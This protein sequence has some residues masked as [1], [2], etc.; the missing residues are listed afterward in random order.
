MSA[1]VPRSGLRHRISDSPGGGWFSSIR[2][3]TAGNPC[4]GSSSCSTALFD[5]GSSLCTST[6]SSP[7]AAWTGCVHTAP[8]R[9]AVSLP[10]FPSPISPETLTR[11]SMTA[12]TA[13]RAVAPARV[14]ASM[15]RAARTPPRGVRTRLRTMRA[16]RGH[17]RHPD[18]REHQFFDDAKVVDRVALFVV[19][20]LI[21]NPVSAIRRR[22][23]VRLRRRSTLRRPAPTAR[24]PFWT[25][26]G[27][28]AQ[29]VRRRVPARGLWCRL[30][31]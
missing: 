26:G 10:V 16:Y 27:G 2:H 19:V 31:R 23:R 4:L 24:S 17:Q 21:S 25:R 9:Y 1:T 7:G 15:R 12:P 3:S 30:W 28:W 29:A 20:H 11:M 14:T 18:T 8:W 6:Y 22:R 5:S 13:G